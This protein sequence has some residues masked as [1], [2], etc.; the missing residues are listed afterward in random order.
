MVFSK[1]AA[2]AAL[3]LALPL[4]ARAEAPQTVNASLRVGHEQDASARLVQ[5]RSWIVGI[6]SK[7]APPGRKIYYPEGQETIEDATA[8]YESIADDLIQVVYD[9]KTPPLFKDVNGRA[10][11]IAVILGVMF[12]ESGFMRQ[13][14][15]GLGKAGRGDHGQSWCSLQIKIGK[16][17]TLKWN[18][19]YNRPVRW[20]DPKDEIFNGYTGPELVNN[21]QLCISEGLKIMKLSFGGTTG[22]PIEDRLRIYAS[23]KRDDGVEKSHSRMKTALTFYSTSAKNRPFTDED[24]MQA[25]ESQ[26]HP[27]IGM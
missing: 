10:R 24:V 16:G 11:T 14:D 8:R 7:A 23:G 12:H 25:L 6:I 18:T 2:L 20:N 3:T 1:T 22:L 13:V 5:V 26:R 17:K 19:K 4:T 27:S 21:R 15:Y 9:P